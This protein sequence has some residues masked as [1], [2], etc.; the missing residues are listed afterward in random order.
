MISEISTTPKPSNNK[1]KRLFLTFLLIAAAL[2]AAY[3][4][5]PSFKGIIGS[6]CL[7]A[8]VGAIYVYNRYMAAIYYYDVMIDSGGTPLFIIRQVIGK[9]ET[10]LCRVELSSIVSVERVTREEMKK[11]TTPEGYVKY[12]YAPTLSPDTA[13]RLTVKSRYERAEITVEGSDEYI[14]MLKAYAAE[15][16]KSAYF[17]DGE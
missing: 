12:Y 2:A 5:S 1:A 16:R 8:V 15:A 17:D 10:T 13:C 9:R 6:L 3:I 7:V 4:A 11:H 14:A